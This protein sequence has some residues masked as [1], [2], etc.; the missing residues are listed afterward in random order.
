[1]MQHECTV[2]A[3]A[4]HPISLERLQEISAECWSWELVT[5]LM[6]ALAGAPHW[7]SE[8]QALLRKI[9]AGE[10]PPPVNPRGS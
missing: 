9:A 7:R 3:L 1:M 8:A 5:A 4:L 6:A 10:L 2:R